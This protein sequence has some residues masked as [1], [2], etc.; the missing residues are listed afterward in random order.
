MTNG[1]VSEVHRIESLLFSD[2]WPKYS[3]KSELKRKNISYPFVVEEDKKILGYIICWYYIEELHI[4]NIAVIPEKQRQGIG[5]FMLQKVFDNFMEYKKAF[6]EVRESNKNAINLYLAFG[7][8]PIYRRKGY[9]TNGEDALVMVKT[10]RIN[11]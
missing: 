5:T 6:L 8:E 7:F 10:R 4:G 1:D 3:F 2:P 11:H 9:Y